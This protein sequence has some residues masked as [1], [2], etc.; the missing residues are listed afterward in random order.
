MAVTTYEWEPREL[1]NFPLVE[2]EIEFQINRL[3]VSVQMS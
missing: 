3:N 1:S 2:G